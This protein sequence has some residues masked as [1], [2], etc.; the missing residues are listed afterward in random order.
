[1]S[2]ENQASLDRRV[3]RAWVEV[4]LRRALSQEIQAGRLPGAQDDPIEA[5][6]LYLQR[7]RP[8]VL[9]EA[10]V[11]YAEHL[12]ADLLIERDHASEA[13]TIVDLLTGNIDL[14][15]PRGDESL[16][17]LSF[18]ENAAIGNPLDLRNRLERTSHAVLVGCQRAEDVPETFRR[19]IDLTVT[20]PPVTEEDFDDVFR[21][22]FG[23]GLPQRADPADVWTRFVL[24]TDLQQPLRLG[25][26]ADAAAA[27]IESRVRDR[28]RLA[29]AEQAPDLAS[30]HGL[31][32][33]RGIAEDLI[34]DL[35][36]AIRGEVSWQEV[37]RGM[38]MVGPPGTGKTTLARAIARA[39]GVTFIATSPARWHGAD[40]GVHLANI[41]ATFDQARRAGAAL[42]FIDEVDGI[43]SRE[44]L[45][46][47]SRSYQAKVINALL[48]ELDGF[49]G[50]E[51]V[52]VIGATN[53]ESRV[54]PALRRAGRLDQVV[55]VPYPNIA[56]LL[57]I[58]RHHLAAHS[59]RGRVDPALDLG[60]LAA[61]TFGLT[62]ADVELFVR[63]AA[64]RA[65]RR[66]D[67]IRQADLVDEIMR[68]PRTPG[69]TG[70]IDAAT[71]ERLAYHEAGHALIG[72]LGPLG[73]ADIGYVSIAPRSDG[74]VGYTAKVPDE[75]VSLT[76]EDV[77]HEIRVCLAGRAAEELRY[78]PGGVSDL[79]ADRGERSDLAIATAN[80]R[81]LRGVSGLV[82][83][84]GLLWWKGVPDSL[85]G[86]LEQLTR[87]TLR[88][89]HAEA[90]AMLARHRSALD[91]LAAE[92]VRTQEI[93][94]AELK[95]LAAGAG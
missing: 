66:G 13:T 26:G 42:V 6:G 53:D 19:L 76:L 89:A 24:P 40:L 82:T 1:M 80:A 95:R 44:R 17:L 47:S 39:C 77:M 63:G 92:L 74:R 33:A 14:G 87:T 10:T 34:A 38:L 90:L 49:H 20:L 73:G 5:F 2:G 75:R 23:A 25:Y 48:E 79:A 59:A 72:L 71:R 50:R 85:H 67:L 91:R 4:L 56:A 78:G 61:L 21:A 3:N 11:P 70:R 12:V 93:S 27:Y 32:A 55:R 16:V 86:E 94:Q 46:A 54:D 81:A 35:A 62:G 65:R 88:Q 52:V 7:L 15:L 83:D 30:L 68:R 29:G 8:V 64:R 45:D 41:R 60:D 51:G 57:E 37:D 31:G 18:Y 58:Y 36:A 43:G 84:A 9:L 28:Q 69:T 22:L